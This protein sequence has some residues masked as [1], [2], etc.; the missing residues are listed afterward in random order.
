MKRAGKLTFFR[1]IR[2]RYNVGSNEWG[3]KY[4]G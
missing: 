4:G 1:Y 3:E 2:C